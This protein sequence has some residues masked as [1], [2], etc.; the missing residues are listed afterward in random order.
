[1]TLEQ[2]LAFYAEY[3]KILTTDPFS[4]PIWLYL[5]YKFISPASMIARGNEMEEFIKRYSLNGIK[6]PTICKP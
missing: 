5:Q 1:M 6:I 2:R 3:V 4:L